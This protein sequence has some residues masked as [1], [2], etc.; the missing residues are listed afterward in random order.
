MVERRINQ[1]ERRFRRDDSY[2]Q[3]YKTFVDCMLEKEYTKKS[4]SPAPLRKTQYIHQHA[5]FNP[6]KPGKF[7]VVFNCSAEVGGESIN[8]N[9]MTGPD[10][11]NQLTEVLIRF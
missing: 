3:Y 2:F 1:L 7:I 11:V 10:L 5:V 9:L 6:N 4:M 8:I